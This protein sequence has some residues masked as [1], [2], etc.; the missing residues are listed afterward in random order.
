M[1]KEKKIPMNSRFWFCVAWLLMVFNPA[2]C[3]AEIINVQITAEKPAVG[4]G[5]SVTVQALATYPDGRRAAGCLLLP[6]V[7]GK[8][9]GGYEYADKQGHATFLLPLPNPGVTAIQVEARPAREQWI[10]SSRANNNQTIYLQTTFEKP[11]D[12]ITG[13]LWIGTDDLAT[14]YIND[15]SIGSFTGWKNR[16]PV[17][18]TKLLQPGCNVL[19]I[20]GF[21]DSGTAGVLVRLEM[22]TPHGLEYLFSDRDWRWFGSAPAGWPAE[23]VGGDRVLLFGMPDGQPWNATSYGWPADTDRSALF[24][25]YAL[26]KSGNLSNSV[27]VQVNPRTLQMPPKDPN[28]LIGAQYCTLFNPYLFTFYNAQA[29][30]LIGYYRSDDPDVIRQHMIWLMESGV[31]FLVIDWVATAQNLQHWAD[32]SADMNRVIKSTTSLLTTLAAMRDEGLAVPKVVLLAG[33]NGGA[34]TI[35]G[36]NEKLNWINQNYINNPLY[37]DLFI[38]YQ[39]KPLILIFTNNIKIPEMDTTNFTIRWY[40]AQLHPDPNNEFWSWMDGVM[41]QSVAYY[42][43]KAEA[44]TASVGF[45]GRS[46]WTGSGAYGRKGGWTLTNSFKSVL[47]HQPRFVQLHQFNEFTG[48]FEGSGYGSSASSVGTYGDSYSVELSDDFEPVSLTTPGYRANNGGWGFF[49]LNLIR[50]LVDLYKQPSPETTVLVA[51]EPSLNQV[52]TTK[53][54]NVQWTTAGRVP[55]GFTISINGQVVAQNLH[56]TSATI[57]L[58]GIKNGTK[59]LR[60]TALGTQ[61]RY[62]LSYKE[63]SQ[64]LA[65]PV[66]AYVDVN[67]TLNIPS[68]TTSVN[69]CELP[70][71]FTLLQNYPNPFNPST[72]IKYSIPK[73]GIV[74]LKV[75]NLLGQEVATIVNQEQKPGN[76]TVNFDASKLASGIYMYSLQAD[77]FSL[78]KQMILQK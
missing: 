36:E 28:H 8:R 20:K 34:M 12:L 66:A 67:F 18:V 56:G 51:S 32:R 59:T 43:G 38:I 48:Q 29:V 69:M 26:P 76:Y 4:M 55:T 3:H 10:W 17:N 23:V 35:S 7:N 33:S 13:Q 65:Q 9:W 19:S 78:T 64:P 71:S 6:Y 30:P 72:E 49:Y 15:Q 37:H 27:Q 74:N 5:R 31:D 47:E 60:L 2:W 54:L 16:M 22:E 58:S 42:Q 50:A 24:V 40:S 11:S 25:G 57:D 21:N 45:F 53:Q 63:D 41:D 52:V 14:V 44:M 46:M 61:S 68:D 75:H 1:P 62:L 77:D 70:K 39:N 73:K